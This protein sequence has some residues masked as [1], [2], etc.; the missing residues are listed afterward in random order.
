MLYWRITQDCE[1]RVM[2]E[3]PALNDNLDS[4]TFQNY[5]FLK[6]ELIRFCRQEGLQTTGGKSLD[7]AIK[8]WNQKKSVQGHNRYEKSDLIAQ[9]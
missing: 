2:P 3:R 4:A 8:C 5:Y 6:D 1:A 7:D 9:T